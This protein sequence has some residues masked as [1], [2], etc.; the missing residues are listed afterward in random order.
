MGAGSWQDGL[1]LGYC[2]LVPTP[3][4]TKLPLVLIL[5]GCCHICLANRQGLTLARPG[6]GTLWNRVPQHQTTF[7]QFKAILPQ[8]GIVWK[9]GY[10]WC[11]RKLDGTIGLSCVTCFQSRYQTTQSK[12]THPLPH[13][14]TY[15]PTSEAE[16]QGSSSYQATFQQPRQHPENISTC[17]GL[18]LSFHTPNTHSKSQ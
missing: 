8:N 9:I 2:C 4:V 15:P 3:A 5:H 17:G 6:Q 18:S 7:R 14:S 11:N 16:E 10:W 1:L 12:L 13:P